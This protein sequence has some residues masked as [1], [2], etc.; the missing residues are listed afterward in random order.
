MQPPT[1]AVSILFHSLVR[2]FQ[3]VHEKCTIQGTW[4]E[5]LILNSLPA[6]GEVQIM[7]FSRSKIGPKLK[8]RKQ[9]PRK[10]S[11]TTFLLFA[12]SFF[13]RQTWSIVAQKKWGVYRIFIQVPS[14]SFSR[15]EFSTLSSPISKNCWIQFS[16]SFIFSLCN[17][18]F[19]FK[20]ILYNVVII[21]ID[22]LMHQVY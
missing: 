16:S 18:I 9:P 22:L 13:L 11:W 15:N 21:F 20:E 19:F 5:N 6:G 14:F 3:S 17:I 2:N 8:G 12:I 7:T 10:S 1:L 4:L